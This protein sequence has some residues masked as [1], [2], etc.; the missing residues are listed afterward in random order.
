MS[1][2]KRLHAE[3][4]VLTVQSDAEAAQSD[5]ET[6]R[7]AIRG[8][9]VD[10]SDHVKLISAVKDVV[11]NGS[12]LL[13]HLDRL[14]QA[15]KSA[16]GD[17]AAITSATAAAIESCDI[18]LVQSL[19]EDLI[20]SMGRATTKAARIVNESA[21]RRCMCNPLMHCFTYLGCLACC[22]GSAGGNE[23]QPAQLSLPHKEAKRRRQHSYGQQ[24]DA[25]V[26]VLNMAGDVFFAIFT[27]MPF[28][29]AAEC[30]LD[31][32]P[33]AT[34]ASAGDS[35]SISELGLLFWVAAGAIALTLIL[36]FCIILRRAPGVAKG[37]WCR[38][39]GALTVGTLFDPGTGAR[40]VAGT[41]REHKEAGDKEW[42]ANRNKYVAR[43]LDP[44]ARQAQNSVKSSRTEINIML[45]LFLFQDLPG[46]AVQTVFALKSWTFDEVLEPVFLLTT[47]GTLLHMYRQ[48]KEVCDL[49]DELPDLRKSSVG[50][51][52]TFQRACDDDVISFARRHN[53]A[54]RR[55]VLRNDAIT[56][57]ASLR[58]ATNENV[59]SDKSLV[60]VAELCPCLR[61]INLWG[62]IDLTD[63]AIIALAGC[64]GLTRVNLMGCHR[65]TD[66]SIVV[67]ARNCHQL[68]ELHLSECKG[69][70][71]DA[72]LAIADNCPNLHTLDLRGCHSISD[73]ALEHLANRCSQLKIINLAGAEVSDAG[74]KLLA[75]RC[76]GLVNINV[77][78]CQHLTDDAIRHVALNCQNITAIKASRCPGLTNSALEA[79]QH[80]AHLNTVHAVG[81]K[82]IT[83]MGAQRLLWS[84]GIKPCAFI[85]PRYA[86]AAAAARGQHHP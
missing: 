78:D 81:C 7:A 68:E 56:S 74:I 14:E 85:T 42:D 33:F 61:V 32:L 69:V 59:I 23:R 67:L 9:A 53:T 4:S 11:H 73:V 24:C 50:R 35:R 1:T 13:R 29:C 84:R 54:V 80:S 38:F 58:K 79:M 52:K 48:L 49:L 72:V 64:H 34:D 83:S 10:G 28:R 22:W 51:D 36:R 25:M 63:A 21:P 57:G 55:I 6:L 45:A 46:I 70:S 8:G 41:M 16:P 62:C 30:G 40:M 17:N 86:I 31:F 18:R 5:W 20:D 37:R 71:D 60:V 12:A 76:R 44:L 77:N 65:L 19:F 3:E 2:F 66:T 27:L 39:I 82:Q 15:A 75:E 26:E 47:L 43:S